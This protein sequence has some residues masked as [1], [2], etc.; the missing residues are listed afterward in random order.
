MATYTGTGSN[1]SNYTGTLTVT[2]SS[3][4]IANNTSTV[5]YSLVLTGNS[6]YYFQQ[7]YVTTKVYVNGV[8][9]DR[10]EQISMPTPS[11]GVSSYTICSG[12]TT[13]PHNNDGTKSITVYATIST[14]TSQTY[15]PGAVNVP[16]GLSGSLTL[17]TI[18]R[19]ST[20]TVPALTIESAGTFTVSAASASFTH[21]ITYSFNG[22][23]GTAAT[24][25]S[26]VTTASWTPPN[27]F[28]AKL[29]NSTYGSISYV[30]HTYSG[31]TEVGTNS[32]TGTI[33]VGT[34]IKPTAPGLTL[35]PV[36][37][38]AWFASKGLYVGGYTKLRVQ[39]SAYPGTGATIASY[40]VSEAFSAT[41]SDVT[42]TN[43]LAA[44]YQSATVTVADSR[45]RTNYN[46]N[47]VYFDTYTNPSLTTFTAERGTYAGG[48]WT[49][50]TVGDHIR[51]TAIGSVSFTASGNYGTITVKIGATSPDATSGDY[52]YFTSTDAT[53]TYNVTGTITDQVGNTTTRGLTVPT[54]EVPFNIN[55]DLP[56]V[57][58]GMIAQNARTLEL[59]QAWHI[60]SNG[61][62][63]R[64]LYMPYS[65]EAV[66]TPGSSGYA[67][68]ATITITETYANSAIMFEVMRRNDNRRVRLYLRF[69]SLGNTDP[70]LA[71]F[72]YESI[73]GASGFAAFVYKTG[74]S[75]WDVYV[76]KTEVYD[77]ISVDTH[78]TPYMMWR[79]SVSYTDAQLSSIPAGATSASAL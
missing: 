19:A 17:T 56:G 22:L 32:Y 71:A 67:R 16:S 46:R 60:T 48:T 65:W 63:N 31:A 59:A 38:N 7:T 57:G 76:L 5:S 50:S 36:N 23:S 55:V 73:A 18:P 10:Y 14:P 26:G 40:T 30:L 47:T 20:M 70:T 42:S 1:N 34:S 52:Y 43:A 15:L 11:G 3:Y 69:N 25:A 79:T 21:T 74:T 9:Q 12:T 51:V 4:S 29:P 24:L 39:S 6:G 45:G 64:M 44:G 35:S 62:Y 53:T 8:V 27:T 54:I 61:K 28:Y 77:Y 68:I 13:V 72:K 37:T 2:E 66:G 33:Y 58:V 41:G 78:M 75:T 49:S